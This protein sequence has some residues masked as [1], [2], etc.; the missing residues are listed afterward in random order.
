MYAGLLF[1]DS[2]REAVE[3]FDARVSGGA[4]DASMRRFESDM[5]M[6]A[7][8]MAVSTGRHLSDLSSSRP[9]RYSNPRQNE[10][11]EEYFAS[12][13]KERLAAWTSYAATIWAQSFP[14]YGYRQAAKR[15]RVDYE[16]TVNQAVAYF[17]N[18]FDPS[19]T[20][21]FSQ[22]QIEAALFTNVKWALCRE[23]SR[24]SAEG[25]SGYVNAASLD[26]PIGDD[27]EGFSMYSFVGD[28]E[29]FDRIIGAADDG[30]RKFDKLYRV[31]KSL[32]VR[33]R[34]AMAMIM[35]GRSPS[36]VSRELGVSR[37]CVANYLVQMRRY[38]TRKDLACMGYYISDRDYEKAWME[39][40][41]AINHTNYSKSLYVRE[42]RE[43]LRAMNEYD[44]WKARQD[45][46]HRNR[47][48]ADWARYN[49]NR[50]AWH[51]ISQKAKI[52]S[53]SRKS[54]E[55]ESVIQAAS[56][57]GLSEGSFMGP[58]DVEAASAFGVVPGDVDPDALDRDIREMI[59]RAAERR[60]N[61]R[62][63][64]DNG[65]DSDDTD[66]RWQARESAKQAEAQAGYDY[67]FGDDEV[68]VGAG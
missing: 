21:S 15:L 52:R 38:F 43:R 13:T 63:D 50:R 12:P 41:I 31:L 29:S 20:R 36:D 55:S 9:D 56:A 51:R 37:Q 58:E 2:G 54:A 1:S 48:K 64:Q 34:K 65:F 26:A 42:L 6:D 66:Y 32:P 14:M 44:E 3:G 46:A 47:L 23:F 33:Q 40:Q 24:Q 22:R 4:R 27:D 67:Y 39:L 18:R 57:S 68:A 16:G 49:R 11:F 62:T 17:C 7:G 5:S 25:R 53:E 35:H 59:A 10:L 8:R 45:Q 60:R 28:D 30:T 19:A 61:V